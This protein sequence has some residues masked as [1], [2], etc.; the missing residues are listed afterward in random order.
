MAGSTTVLPGSCPGSMP[1]PRPEQFPAILG[2]HFPA[3]AFFSLLGLSCVHVTPKSINPPLKTQVE[4]PKVPQ[5]SPQAWH[6]CFFGVNEAER[7]W[8]GTQGYAFWYR[9]W[10]SQEI[11]PG[12]SSWVY[13][14]RRLGWICLLAQKCEDPWFTISPQALLWILL[15]PTNQNMLKPTKEWRVMP[16]NTVIPSPGLATAVSPLS[17]KVATL[18]IS[19]NLTHL[20]FRVE[21][22]NTAEINQCHVGR[23]GW[24][25]RT[26]TCWRL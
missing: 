12:L 15:A 13:K 9:L 18:E 2:P 14:V 26:Q 3:Q 10:A 16:L 7:R 24:L 22:R 11:S 8:D 23:G 17:R 4:K 5:V 1:T 21:K 6:K 25:R 20:R 19:N